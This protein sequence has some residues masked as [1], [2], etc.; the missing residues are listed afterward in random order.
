MSAV[1]GRFAVIIDP[2]NHNTIYVGT[3]DL[4]FGSFSMGSQGILKSTDAGATWHNTG[5][6]QAGRIGRIIVHPKDAN[7][8]YACVA[9]RLTGPIPTSFHWRA[10]LDG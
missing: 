8:V 6:V 2:S 7:V 1:E 5:L 4:N 10:V 9:G 3:G